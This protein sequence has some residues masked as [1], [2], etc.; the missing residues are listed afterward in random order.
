[1]AGLDDIELAER[2]NGGFWVRLL[3]NRRAN[4]CIV[5]VADDRTGEYFEVEVTHERALD[6]FYH[7]FAYTPPSTGVVPSPA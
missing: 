3:W 2:S 6:A 5:A 7:P 4:T 1:M